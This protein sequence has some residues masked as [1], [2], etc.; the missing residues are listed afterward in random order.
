MAAFFAPQLGLKAVDTSDIS[1]LP[2]E[3]CSTSSQRFQRKVEGLLGF[4]GCTS[5][6]WAVKG[7]GGPP[8]SL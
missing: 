6:Q 8:P 4:W 3:V 2:E 5:L 7:G 1:T